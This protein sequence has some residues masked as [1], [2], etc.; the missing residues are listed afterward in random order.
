VEA[1]E[2]PLVRGANG[3]QILSGGAGLRPWLP[4]GPPVVDGGWAPPVDVTLLSPPS[5]IPVSPPGGAPVPPHGVPPASPVLGASLRPSVARQVVRPRTSGS[6]YLLPDRDVDPDPDRGHWSLIEHDA[7]GR[8]SEGDAPAAGLSPATPE[9]TAAADSGPVSERAALFEPAAL[10]EPVPLFEPATASEP[11]PLFESAT[12]SESA[13]LPAPSAPPEISSRTPAPLSRRARRA[14]EQAIA[15]A[16]TGETRPIDLP[17]IDRAPVDHSWGDHDSAVPSTGFAP[18]PDWAATLPEHGAPTAEPSEP[19][20]GWS[21]SRIDHDTDDWSELPDFVRPAPDLTWYSSIDALEPLPADSVLHDTID[22][23]PVL[24][25]VVDSAR[26]ESPTSGG[27]APPPSFGAPPPLPPSIEQV[28]PPPADELLA[29]EPPTAMPVVGLFPG[30]ALT[31]PIAPQVAG[32][33]ALPDVTSPPVEL[34]APPSE[35]LGP[36]VWSAP[37]PLPPE[38]LGS[39]E[40]AE[41]PRAEFPQAEFPRAEWSS[42]EPSSPAPHLPLPSL[43]KQLPE[44]A[45]PVPPPTPSDQA[46]PQ[47]AWPR[48]AVLVNDP[49]SVTRTTSSI[50]VIRPPSPVRRPDD[51]S[52]ATTELRPV[53]LAVPDA[54]AI[55]TMPVA[56]DKGATGPVPTTTDA[57]PRPVAPKPP[58]REVD[59]PEPATPYRAAVTLTMPAGRQAAAADRPAASEPPRPRIPAITETDARQPGSAQVNAPEATHSEPGGR[60]TTFEGRPSHLPPVR[61]LSSAWP[62][63]LSPDVSRPASTIVPQRGRG[64]SKVKKRREAVAE[65]VPHVP[66]TAEPAWTPED[67]SDAP[68]EEAERSRLLS[69]IV[70]WAPAFILLVLAGAVVWVV[71]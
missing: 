62:D 27:F 14:A 35:R 36:P 30:Q 16:A 21:D 67:R 11:V 40:S 54:K 41:F 10:S 46:V 48:P 42:A 57:M 68:P 34:P 31:L 56:A 45:A 66:A 38:L 13:L 32:V 50:P 3:E 17:Q 71:R 52:A 29:L 19:A 26:F 15:A 28:Q 37:A 7:H 39:P 69:V 6:S 1:T 23:A 60:D 12:A 64:R 65:P 33:A 20:P 53:R 9:H 49:T 61:T 63:D 22:V 44:V 43:P 8:H 70:F 58:A 5:G 4:P 59:G 47:A 51:D 18:V 55:F 24:D 2:E 25:S